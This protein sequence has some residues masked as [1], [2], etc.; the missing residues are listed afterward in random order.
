MFQP[1]NIRGKTELGQRHFVNPQELMKPDNNVPTTV[2]KT[3]MDQKT[4]D[5]LI[6]Q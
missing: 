3:V 6:N 4:I 1:L 2:D 5:R